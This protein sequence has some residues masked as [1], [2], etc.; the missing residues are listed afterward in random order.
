MMRLKEDWRRRARCVAA[1]IVAS[2]LLALAGCSRSRSTTDERRIRAVEGSGDVV[3][4]VVWPWEARQNM[5][6]SQGLN[7]AVVEVNDAGGVHRRHLRLRHE[8][9]QEAV[10]QGRLIA[11]RLADDPDVVA[12][13]GHLQ[14]YVTVPAAAIYDEAGLVLLAPAATSAELTSKGYGRVFRLTVND[15]ATG[16]QMA[17]YA[18]AQGYQRIAVYYE[19]S[20]YGRALANAFEEQLATSDASVLARNSYDVGFRPRE[21]A[22][23]EMLTRWRSLDLDAIFLAG[24]TP[25]A[26]QLVAL[27]RKL[28]M[29][30]PVLGGDA[31][32]SPDFI[33]AG[34][35]AVEGTVV[36]TFFHPEDPRPEV[37]KF[38]AAF[39][40]RYGF[41]PDASS[42]LGYDA[43][44]LLAH[45]MNQA[46]SPAPAEVAEVLHDQ[47]GWAGVT[48]T[49]KF[50]QKGELVGRNV[51]K[52]VVKDGRL[53]YLEK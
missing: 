21:G 28:G 45:A 51:I 2:G 9:D 46:A 6:Y 3:V 32:S 22:L 34:G 29:E 27:F 31:M 41:D 20:I 43:V 47:A 25:P 26:G 39:R 44:R 35:K 16:G 10:N 33:K 42:A 38:V 49:F 12:V 18:V 7:L 19:R 50:D 52:G 5:L 37:Q 8:D 17:D 48:G 40:A 23:E 24:Q 30:L 53:V 14:S 36:A 15:Q 11:Q 1:L 4:A 13:I